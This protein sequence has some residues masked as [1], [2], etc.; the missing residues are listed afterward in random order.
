MDRQQ[1]LEELKH[2]YVELA[3]KLDA[4]QVAWD[5]EEGAGAGS[6]FLNQ[7]PA[8]GI[9]A[10]SAHDAAGGPLGTGRLELGKGQLRLELDEGP[11]AGGVRVLGLDLLARLE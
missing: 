7:P 3:V 2:N 4:E 5:P 1:A 10:V 9:Y 8:P 11:G 6:G